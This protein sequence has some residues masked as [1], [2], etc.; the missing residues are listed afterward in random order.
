MRH[1]TTLFIALVAGLALGANEP[2]PTSAQMGIVAAHLKE[3][4]VLG[5]IPSEYVKVR[6]VSNPGE[7]QIALAVLYT[8]ERPNGSGNDYHRRLAVFLRAGSGLSAPID[9]IVGG[10]IRRGLTL[11][12]VTPDRV[13]L[14][15]MNY[16][17]QDPVC[18]PSI[19]GVV[20]YRLSEGALIEAGSPN[21]R[22]QRSGSP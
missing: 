10:A 3:M 18:C 13:I 15:A 21:N 2:T 12:E 14:D 6:A 22:M 1:L 8:H 20:T 17:S 9:I 5:D 19:P 11:R 4:G 7:G 16:A